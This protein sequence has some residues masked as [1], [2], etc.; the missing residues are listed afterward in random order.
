GGERVIVDNVTAA[1]PIAPGTQDKFAVEVRLGGPGTAPLKLAQEFIAQYRRA[2]PA[3]LNWRDRRP[4][5][6]LFFN[7]GLPGEQAVANLQDPDNARLPP[8]DAKYQAFVL[9]RMKT[10][11]EAAKAA[12]A[13]GVLL[14]DLEGNTFPHATTYIG[15]PRL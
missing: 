9:A 14:W 12:N 1:R 6:R 8:P 10:C 5:L 11:V 2:H 7:G 13:Q 15:D 4:I 3:L